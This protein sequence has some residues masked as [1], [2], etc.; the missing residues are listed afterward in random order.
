[1]RPEDWTNVS[2]ICAEALSL[3]PEE[4]GAFVVEACGGDA[5]LEL[6]VMSLLAQDPQG[7]PLDV[8]AG[9]LRELAREHAHSFEAGDRIGRYRIVRRAGRGGMGQ[10]Y[11]AVSEDPELR[12]RV[13]LKVIRRGMD[14]EDLLLRFRAER[15]ILAQ[16]DHPN[17]AR[18]LDAGMTEDGRP[19]FAMEYVDGLPITE[20][21]ARGGLSVEERLRLFHQVC[22]AA[23]H[24]HRSL[25][26][27][28][29]LKPANVLVTAEG[30]PK[31][32][33]FG[34]AKVLDPGSVSGSLPV[35]RTGEAPMTPEYASPEQVGGQAITTASDVYSLGVVLYELLSGRLP[36]VGTRSEIARA[37]LESE[38]V[39]PSTAVASGAT[40]VAGPERSPRRLARRL[41]GDLDNVVL[42]ALRKE[43]ERRYLSLQQFADDVERHLEGRPVIARKETLTYL[44][45]KFVRRNPLATF[46][47]AVAL[48]VLLGFSMLTQAQSRRIAHQAEV[49][50]SERDTA[51]LA[52]TYLE[53]LFVEADPRVALGSEVTARELLERGRARLEQLDGQPAVQARLMRSIGR[54]YDGIG[55]AQEAEDVLRDALERSRGLGS[56]ELAL[57]ESELAPVLMKRGQLDEASDLLD[58]ALA[59]WR[60]LDEGRG[61]FEARQLQRLGWIA[62]NRG[63]LDEAERRLREGEAL[64]QGLEDGARLRAEILQ[65]LGAVLL[66]A[67]GPDAAEPMLREAHAVLLEVA[68]AGD[69]SVAFSLELLGRLATAR[70]E[71]DVA[72]EHLVRAFELKSRVYGADSVN[73]AMSRNELAVAQRRGGNLEAAEVNYR[74]SRE[75]LR[76]NLGDAHWFVVQSTYNLGSVQFQRG[77]LEEAEELLSHALETARGL[78]PDD[79]PDL[80][81]LARPLVEL[82][83]RRRRFEEAAFLAEDSWNICSEVL[84]PDEGLRVDTLCLFGEALA[85]VGEEQPALELLDGEAEQLAASLGEEHA[86]TARV[87]ALRERL[88][89][90]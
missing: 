90:N 33:D 16:L 78:R 39:R 63:R 17:I 67:Q 54:A 45:R 61:L 51:E 35:T 13:A 14:S 68:P 58:A 74:A 26:V 2:R 62:Q 34:I 30:V 89:G 11:E 73:V 27:H 59:R 47:S 28:R 55:L 4:R 48:L 1:M 23:H 15:R 7:G 57:S 88:A 49:V 77:R 43:P 36:N 72:E 21:C 37:I 79:H 81:H 38:P 65:H 52:T 6:E 80:A 44:T 56:R 64:L 71:Y 19:Y 3:A 18:F 66:Q 22:M 75:T 10:V 41:R 42:M 69:P 46:S 83:I 31:L 12:R 85:G 60:G 32:L 86:L 84:D 9:S 53:D 76:A 25:I 87:R 5:R 8:P 20:Y 24:A 29:D 82:L 50:A 70:G 40:T